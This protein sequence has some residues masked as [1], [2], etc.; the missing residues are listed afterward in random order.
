MTVLVAPLVLCPLS[1]GTNSIIRALGDQEW[2]DGLAT[3]AQEAIRNVLPTEIKHFL[4][5]KQLGHP[6]HPALIDLPLG[7]WTLAAIFDGIEIARGKGK[8]GVADAA[9]GI[10]LIGAV[11]AA[12]AGLT[13]WSETDGRA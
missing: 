10:G 12:V 8:N 1:V 3:P 7:A 13:D 9:I 6:L 4:H 2:L 5:G 11:A